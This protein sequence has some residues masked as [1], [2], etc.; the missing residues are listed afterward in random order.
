MS[1]Q[2]YQRGLQGRTTSSEERGSTPVN[3]AST[4]VHK[5]ASS[6]SSSQ[7]DSRQ[8]IF[9]QQEES[10][11]PWIQGMAALWV[12][13]TLAAAVVNITVVWI[14]EGVN[15]WDSMQETGRVQNL[16]NHETK[17]QDTL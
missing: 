12:T 4:P 16:V 9:Q 6:S 13:A 11:K 5:S 15:Q 10:N 14:T 8:V 17:T 2:Q 1:Y 3:K 7:R